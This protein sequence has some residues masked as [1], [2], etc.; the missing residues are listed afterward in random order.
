MAL[1]S[2]LFPHQFLLAVV[3]A[4]S[5]VG[6]PDDP[7]RLL[8]CTYRLVDVV[9]EYSH[10][11]LHGPV[12]LMATLAFDPPGRELFEHWHFEIFHLEDRAE[13]PAFL[14]DMHDSGGRDGSSFY[15]L[16]GTEAFCVAEEHVAVSM[17][18]EYVQL[19]TF[20]A[21]ELDFHGLRA[22]LRNR[23]WIF[24]QYVCG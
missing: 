24:A 5:S 16:Q 1:W 8:T 17:A 15:D 6:G 20:V 23:V 21:S 19:S 18:R 9:R 14:P 2:G 12:Q 7:W 13:L 11:F 22:L 10:A 4:F 3:G